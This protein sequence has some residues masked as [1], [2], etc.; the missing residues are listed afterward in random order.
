MKF[1]VVLAV[2]FLAAIIPVSRQQEGKPRSWMPQGRF[3]KRV[4]EQPDEFVGT[5]ELRNSKYNFKYQDNVIF[6]YS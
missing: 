3:G 4:L 1:A 6:L 2:V 5:P